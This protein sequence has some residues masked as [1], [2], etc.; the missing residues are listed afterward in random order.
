MV[1]QTRSIFEKYAEKGGIFKEAVFEKSGH[2]PQIEEPEKFV[3][4]YEDFLRSI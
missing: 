4:E 2:S 1:T 3:K